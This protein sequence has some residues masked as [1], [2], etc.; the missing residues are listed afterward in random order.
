MKSLAFNDLD[1]SNK[2]FWRGFITTSFPTALDEESDMSLTEIIEE[3]N[4]ANHKWWDDFTGYYDGIL[5]ETD[6]YL[7]DPKMFLCN[8]TPTEVLKVEFHP[9]DTVYFINNKEIAC[10]GA[11]YHIH[12]FSFPELL[13]YA[14]SKSNYQIL[15]LLLPLTYIKKEDAKDAAKIIQK[16]LNKFF[17]PTFIEQITNSIVCGLIEE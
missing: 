10:T 4:L 2:E 17:S 3:N 1:F 11:H 15:L 9:S 5:D 16:V 14:K 13:E 7:D 6:G 12:I 8:L